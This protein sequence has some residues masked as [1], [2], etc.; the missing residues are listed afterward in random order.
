[1]AKR[2]TGGSAF[3]GKSIRNRPKQWVIHPVLSMGTLLKGAATDVIIRRPTHIPA[4]STRQLRRILNT[5]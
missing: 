5:P 2:L 3:G 1:M 4:H